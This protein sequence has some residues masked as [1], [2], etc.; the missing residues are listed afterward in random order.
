MDAFL[1]KPSGFLNLVVPRDVSV[2]KQKFNQLRE[3]GVEL[4][5]GTD[6]GDPGYSI[7]SSLAGNG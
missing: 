2:E 1:K 4:L 6:S 3:L 5:V 7:L